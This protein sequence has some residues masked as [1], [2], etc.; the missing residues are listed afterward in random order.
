MTNI[1]AIAG[2]KQSGK[3]TAVN[4]LHGYEMKRH[5]FI[6]YF[7]VSPEGKLLVN[8][9]Y[10]DE[11]EENIERAGI[12]ELEQKS[13]AFTN[14]AANSFWP[15]VRG[16][17]FASPLK[18]ICVN[19]FGLS[20]E[21]VYG[22][23]EQKNSLTQFRWEEMPGVMVFEKL[24]EE[25][26]EALD[27]AGLAEH[28]YWK[29]LGKNDQ[30]LMTGR[31]FMQFAGTDVFRKMYGK[32]WTDYCLQDIQNTAPDLALISDCRFENEITAV[33]AIGGKVIYLTRNE[34]SGGHSSEKAGEY[35]D[36]YDAVIDNVNMTIPEQTEAIK[37]QLCEWGILRA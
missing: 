28:L 33:Q 4:Y 27:E 1:V 30:P 17:S 15:F 16:F 34:T 31:E 19:L 13:E 9:L 2:A 21:Q 12:F 14:Y 22:T 6:K 26:F 11:N 8:A 3:S 29:K 24:D 35:R 32:I 25:V 37:E 23:N 5:G 10:K 36:M 7:D 20:P 18:E